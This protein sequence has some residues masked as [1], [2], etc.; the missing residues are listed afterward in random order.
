CGML[1][2]KKRRA[3][4]AAYRDKLEDI[5][6]RLQG[7]EAALTLG[8]HQQN[9][10]HAALDLRKALEGLLLSSL[11]THKEKLGPIT[12]ALKKLDADKAKK[13]V[14]QINPGWWPKPQNLGPGPEGTQ[15]ALSGHHESDFMTSLDWG[16]AFGVVSAV[17]HET[18]PFQLKPDLAEVHP[19]LLAILNSLKRL[20]QFHTISIAE[21]DQLI[22]AQ[23]SYEP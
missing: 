17:V 12:K 19:K 20:L 23:A 16:P 22:F 15:F 5:M 7:A 1:D 18:N 8:V 4:L 2:M 6:A 14:E 9:V 13:T 11:V 3:I 10:E 21:E